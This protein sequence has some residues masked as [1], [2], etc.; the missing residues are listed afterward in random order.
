MKSPEQNSF[1]LHEFVD[2][3]KPVPYIG[4][5][6]EQTIIHLEGSSSRNIPW[7]GSCSAATRDGFMTK[8]NRYDIDNSRLAPTLQHPTKAEHDYIK[9]CD[10]Q[11]VSY[12]PLVAAN[13]ADAQS[14]KRTA[15]IAEFIVEE[16][17]ARRESEIPRAYFDPSDS[18]PHR[19]QNC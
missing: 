7:H 18:P 4:V 14:K 2:N 19:I 16:Q 1:P 6:V 15:A 5:S 11:P 8:I 13:K 3:Y 10:M 17:I 9:F 12:H